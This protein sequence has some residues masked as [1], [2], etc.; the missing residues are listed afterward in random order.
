MDQY[1]IGRLFIELL[2]HKPFSE[3]LGPTSIGKF[4][5]HPQSFIKSPWIDNHPQLWNIV[6]RLIQKN[7]NKRFEDMKQ[8]V[9][10]IRNVEEEYRALAKRT[11][12]IIASMDNKMELTHK[13]NVDFFKQF[14]DR[15]FAR[16]QR[17]KDMFDAKNIKGTQMYER[18]RL[19]M[20][21]VLNFTPGNEPTSLDNILQRHKDLDITKAEFQEF[22]RS[23]LDTLE[24]FFP[25]DP[26]IL[27][28]WEKLFKPI[29]DY[30]ISKCCKSHIKEEDDGG[31]VGK[32]EPSSQPSAPHFDVGPPRKSQTGASTAQ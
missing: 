27:I 3:I 29:T 7:P 30:M 15:F 24:H 16:S 12:L 21:A 32:S 19:A 6:E 17:A 14:Y 23:F 25:N 28:A 31:L 2:E 11:Y 8:V 26:D 13:T 20:S 5:D 10:N 1:T 9:E 4:W 22:E 18:L